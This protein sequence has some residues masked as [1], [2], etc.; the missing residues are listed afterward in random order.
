MMKNVGPPSSKKKILHPPATVCVLRGVCV[1]VLQLQFVRFGETRF[2]V[3]GL[4]LLI[5]LIRFSF[6]DSVN[7]FRYRCVYT[8][9]VVHI[10]NACTRVRTCKARELP[11]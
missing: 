6:M 8:P 3:M 9:R 5:R 11:I 2:S 10:C 4:L 7:V 1:C